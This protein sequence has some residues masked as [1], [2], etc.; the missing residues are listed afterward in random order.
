MKVKWELLDIELIPKKLDSL[1]K[2][3]LKNNNIEVWVIE[4]IEMLNWEFKFLEINC[5]WWSMMFEWKDE[6]QIKNMISDWWEYLY[7][8]HKVNNKILIN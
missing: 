5:L 4:F 7:K 1:A 2:T 6:D 3:V 8:K